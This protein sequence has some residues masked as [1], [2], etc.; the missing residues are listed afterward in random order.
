MH[1]LVF[2]ALRAMMPPKKTSKQKI[3]EKFNNICF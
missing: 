2:G 3:K 1:A